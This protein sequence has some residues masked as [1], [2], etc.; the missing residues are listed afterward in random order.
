LWE[1]CNKISCYHLFSLHFVE[2]CRPGSSVTHTGRD[3]AIHKTNFWPK[4]NVGEQARKVEDEGSLFV[5]RIPFNLA[6][7]LRD[8]KLGGEL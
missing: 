5:C 6:L 2:Q 4:V 1:F 7:D 8:W 3:K